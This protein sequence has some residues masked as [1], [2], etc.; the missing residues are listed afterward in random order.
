MSYLQ[1]FQQRVFT[2]C[3]TDSNQRCNSL[4]LRPTVPSEQFPPTIKTKPID[5]QATINLRYIKKNREIKNVDT[6]DHRINE[7]SPWNSVNVKRCLNL[8]KPPLLVKLHFQLTCL[9]R[10]KLRDFNSC[11]WC[12]SRGTLMAL[13]RRFACGYV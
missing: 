1:L 11:L 13:H 8:S 9:C 7:Q 2:L 10:V 4:L 3:T 5:T 6:K 12:H